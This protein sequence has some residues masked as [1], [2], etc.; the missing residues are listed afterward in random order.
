MATACAK[1]VDTHPCGQDPGHSCGETTCRPTWPNWLTMSS[2]VM[3]HRG[4]WH[5]RKRRGW[6]TIAGAGSVPPASQPA[7][8]VPSVTRERPGLGAK[9]AAP[10]RDNGP[11]ASWQYRTSEASTVTLRTPTE[12]LQQGEGSQSA[13]YSQGPAPT[14]STIMPTDTPHAA[15]TSSHKKYTSTM[16]VTSHPHPPKRTPP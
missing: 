3:R 6:V 8:P 4:T 9:Q 10:A 16:H 1:Q 13:C 11:R 5:R 14:P 15:T 12:P 2:G 7:D